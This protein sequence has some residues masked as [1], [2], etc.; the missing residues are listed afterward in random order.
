MILLLVA[1]VLAHVAYGRV[2]PHTRMHWACHSPAHPCDPTS[3]RLDP[4]QA[5]NNYLGIVLYAIVIVTCIF[6][7]LQDKATADVLASIKGMMASVTTVI[8][9]GKEL[10]ISPEELVPGDV[11]RLTLGDRVPADMRIIYTADLKTESSSLTGEPDAIAATVNAVHEAPIE[12]R[13]LVFSSSLVMNGEGFGVVT[14][15]GDHTMIGSIASLAAG[16]GQGHSETLLEMEVHRFVNFIAVMAIISAFVLFG[17]G[18]GRHRPPIFSFVN[19]FIVVVVAN[20]PEGL[21]A[22][23]TS[24]LS[25]TAKRMAAR[26]VLVKRTNII[27][28]LGSATVIAS[29]KT[30]TLT[31]NRMTVENL[32]YC[33]SVF[34]AYAGGGPSLS[35]QMSMA[36]YRAGGGSAFAG[37]PQAGGGRQLVSMDPLAEDSEVTLDSA[38]ASRL[39]SKAMLAGS[40]RLGGSGDGSDHNV[41]MNSFTISAF[42]SQTLMGGAMPGGKLA[43]ARFSPHA[44]LLTL[45]GVCN[46]ARYEDSSSSESPTAPGVAA[47]D[48]PILGDA[49]DAGLLRYCDK[50]Y[51]VAIARRTFPKVFEIPFNSVNKWSLAVV[52]DP[53]Q[54]AKQHLV[55]MKGAPEIIMARCTDYM[56]LG[57]ASRPIDDDFREEYV[58]AYERFGSCGERV[59]GFAYAVVPAQKA[60]AYATEAGAPP[61][62]GLTFAGLISLV[63][64]PRPGVAEAIQLCRKAGIRVT[65]VTGD[66]P[67]TAEAIARKVSIITRATRRDVAMED[68][69]PEASVPLSDPRV[70]AVVITGAQVGGL[71]QED[72]DQILSKK[73]VV[74]ARTSPQ[75]KLKL[76]ENYQRRGEVVAVTGDGVNDSPALKRAQIGVAMGSKNA[77]D[78]AREAADIILLD[79]NFASIVNA[80]EEGR[81]L[82]D[83]LKKTIAYTLAHLWPELVPVFLN[84]AFSF[85]LAMNGLM[86]LT[87]DLLTEQGPA[88]SLAY[89]ISESAVMLRPPRNVK[90]DRL[91]S[92]PSLFYSYVVAGLGSSL[93]CMGC[94]F[95]VY[96]RA[97]IPVT[98]LAFSLDDGYFAYPPFTPG[99]NN[100][101]ISTA[102]NQNVVVPILVAQSTGRQLDAI[103]QWD[104]FCESQ[105]AWYLTLILNQFWHIW[106]CRTRVVSIFTH[107]ITGN[108]V[109]I[110]GAVAEIAI[111]CAVVYI[112][113]FNQANAFQTLPVHGI[114]WLPHF[115]FMAFIFSYNETVKWYVRNQPQSRVARWLGW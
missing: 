87:I 74:F 69:V 10:R 108:I 30:G 84:L 106:N 48:R 9:D 29:D 2:S 47:S 86:V 24:C 113:A 76:V 94:F 37:Q 55:F 35:E 18:M 92:A 66:H 13:N 21:P 77:S 56:A 72:W 3:C 58:S 41:T 17:I 111:A 100:T 59:L 78:V 90:T 63:D 82:F 14:R 51:P 105:G 40:G 49:S 16:S 115:I 81:T 38:G 99:P 68:G 36:G 1:G 91:V 57:G 27:E 28:S 98:Q 107:G 104:L 109:T 61:T 5:A 22:T 43:W 73:E 83:N 60:E 19:G 50:V 46:R 110:Y 20:V 79:D 54:P 33:R 44:R 62:T 95:L 89:E 26:N 15:T 93:V 11:V 32:W 23:V 80:I 8:R 85:P 25:I 65:M 4:T 7:F 102:N 52:P 101:W 64:P 42:N 75:Q 31:Q 34:N 112:P 97:G 53:G 45:A 96:Q 103:Q 71:T 70:E 114:F 12:C 6:T 39:N 88:I 67:L